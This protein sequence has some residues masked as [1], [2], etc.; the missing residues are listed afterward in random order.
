[1]TTTPL[2]LITALARSG[3]LERA[4]ALFEMGGYLA[5]VN[6]PAALAVKGRLL[7]DRGLKAQGAP[8]RDF[9]AQSAAAYAAA[10]AISPA[11]YLLINVATLAF[12]SGDRKRGA[13]FAQRVLDRLDTEAQIAETPYWLSATRAEALLLMGAMP[14]A[15]DALAKAVAQAPESWTDHASTL[16]QFRMILEESA[17]DT[18]WLDPHRPPQ[19]AHFAGHLGVSGGDAIHLRERVSALIS[20]SRIG[21]AYG[22]LAAGA[23]IVIAEAVL[24]AGAALHVILPVRQDSY[25]TQSV[26]RVMGDEWPARY[27]RCIAAASSITEISHID[28]AFEPLA[29]GLAGDVAMG[30]TILNARL[31]ESTACQIIIA[32]DGPGPYGS[33]IHTA[34]DAKRWSARGHSQFILRSPRSAAVVASGDSAA[35]TPVPSRRLVAM[36]HARLSGTEMLAEGDWIRVEKHILSPLRAA[37]TTLPVRPFFN[38]SFNTAMTMSYSEVEAALAAAQALLARFASIDLAA[39]ALPPSLTLTIG[40]H[41][42]IAHAEP[43]DANPAAQ[44]YGHSVLFA[45]EIAKRAHPGSLCVSETFATALA[46]LAGGSVQTTLIGDFQPLGHDKI[47]RLFAVS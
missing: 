33:G 27:Q 19:S 13:L 12:L 34:R 4:W 17:A 44:L 38:Q 28:G 47:I 26:T 37:I 25:I 22:A 14:A 23:D 7:K 10:D 20:A 39:L 46:F 36:L 29:I 43:V 42:D 40:A 6:D 3:A 32:D 18:G 5:A 35:E 1:M 2:S 31:L 15:D 8:R 30:S 24:G 41:Y 21:F 9:F 16:R 11:P 45:E